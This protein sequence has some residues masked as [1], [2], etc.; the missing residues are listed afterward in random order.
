[1]AETLFKLV[2]AERIEVIGSHWTNI[3]FAPGGY[4]AVQ[5]E[6]GVW[7]PALQRYTTI[8]TYYT[9]EPNDA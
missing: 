4:A 5:V 7:K 2:P 8:I 9:L 6:K 1:M 3:Q